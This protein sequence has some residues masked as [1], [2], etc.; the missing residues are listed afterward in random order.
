MF[1]TKNR[2]GL[3]AVLL[4]TVV[5]FVTAC[6]PP[7]PRALLQGRRLLE[8]G[9]TDAAVK[10]LKTA[11][12]LLRTN[13]AAWNYLGLAYHR[14]G[15]STNAIDAYSRAIKLDRDLLEARFNL[16]CLLLDENRP[17]AAKTELTAYT[18]RRGTEPEGWLKL[19]LAQ[20][21]V[22]D[23]ASAEKSF[24]EV[25]RLETNNV[26][27]LNNI[28]LV[29]LQRNRPR[30]AAEAFGSALEVK[31]DYRPALL[32]LAT[33]SQQQLNDPVQALRRYRQYLALQP[34]AANWDAVNAVVR[35]LEQPPIPTHPARTL[36]NN[37][38]SNTIP[39]TAIAT[40][41]SKA[42]TQQ[43]AAAK[44]PAVSKPL[45]NSVPLKPNPG[46]GTT[47]PPPT[48][49]HP[50]PEV[51]RI[52]PEPVVKNVAVAAEPKALIVNSNSSPRSSTPATNAPAPK[53]ERRG[54]LS[55]LNPFKSESKPASNTQTSTGMVTSV[56]A[57]RTSTSTASGRYAY[58]LPKAPG[59]GDRR[60]AENAL[61]QGQQAQRLDRNVEAFQFYR[62]AAQLDPAYFEAH[63]CLGLTAFK[64]RSFQTALTAWENAL[65]L[66][67]NDPDARYNFAL[68]LKAADYPKD[69]ADE[70]EKLLSLHPDEAR[71]HLTLG[72]L[73]ADKLRDIPRARKHYNKVL[74]LDPRNPQAQAIRYW[75]VSN[76]G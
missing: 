16:G 76:P 45:S 10:E 36:T 31:P 71:G 37:P 38:V 64:I 6:G 15:L 34:R 8:A 58:L 70:L 68:T 62:R 39:S 43:V 69:A 55:K 74:Q 61:A 28:G 20:M 49:S 24:R 51:V 50:P 41:Q 75:L 11:V 1:V 13:A 59:S 29:Q 26:E 7:G 12:S 42:P 18:L 30:E 27:A 14:A 9:E 63:Y 40:N 19:G 48:V 25:L 52:A 46:P 21:R 47:S 65:A 22:R 4:L 44:T 17:D 67:P 53:T 5:C 23:T 35:A 32:N 73:Y 60:E 56:M 54:F 66:R 57:E 72:N 2:V 33:V 3:S